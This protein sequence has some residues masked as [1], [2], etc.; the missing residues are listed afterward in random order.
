MSE[1]EQATPEQPSK[2]GTLVILASVA[3]TV[4]AIVLAIGYSVLGNRQPSAPGGQSPSNPTMTASP[5]PTPAISL[6]TG[7][8]APLTTRV[9]IGSGAIGTDIAK[10]IPAAFKAAERSGPRVTPWVKA[11]KSRGPV[12]ATATVGQTGDP[13][14][15]FRAFANLVND[16]P[17]NSIDVAIMALN[18]EDITAETDISRVFENYASTM[19]SIE[20]ANPDIKFLYATV[21]VT[22]SNSWRAVDAATV[23]GLI[24]VN[25]PVW[26]DNIARERFNGLIR[27][28][29]ASSGRLFDIAALEARISEGKAAAKMHENQWYFVM[30]PSLSSNGKR[31]GK[32]GAVQ[33]ADMLVRLVAARVKS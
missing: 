23:I 31:L 8:L 33:L 12:I 1:N 32:A 27:S 3:A 10:G 20:Q 29:Y 5:G 18:Y 15:R 26:Q 4:L 7:R 30:N 21:P 9:L 24:D 11:R 6:P 17:L 2:R 19:E 28:Q 14:S 25:Q 16:A 22:T 13:E